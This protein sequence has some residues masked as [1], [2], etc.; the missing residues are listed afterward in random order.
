[1]GGFSGLAKSDNARGIAYILC[2][3]LCAV[4]SSAITKQLSQDF[5]ATQISFIRALVTLACIT[6]FMV[7]DRFRGLWPARLKLMTL[8][9][10]NAGVIVVLNVYA[11]GNLPLVDFTAITFTTPMFVIVLS[12]FLLRQSPQPSRTIATV[13]GFIGVLCMVRPTGALS[14]ALLAAFSGAFCLGLGVLFIRLLAGKESQVRLLLW[15]NTMLAAVL[16]V[17]AWVTWTVPSLVQT[18]LLVG[19]GLAGA[20]TQSFVLLGYT[21]GDPTVIAPFD[22]SRILLA[23][24]IGA[25]AFGE[26]PD[27]MTFFGAALIIGPGLYIARRLG[28]AY[29]RQAV[30]SRRYPPHRCASQRQR[31]QVPPARRFGR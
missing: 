20:L 16:I 12:I 26:M 28:H 15:S 10:I 17:P 3:S 14:P 21:K 5:S 1:M 27:A 18:L 13:I 6:P 23:V 24:A 2:A 31:P 9:S 7:G 29:P 25:V 4:I 8:R 30:T 22:Y 11:V 19:G